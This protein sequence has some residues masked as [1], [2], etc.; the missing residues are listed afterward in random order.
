VVREKF[1]GARGIGPFWRDFPV[2]KVDAPHIPGHVPIRI[3]GPQGS[4]PKENPMKPTLTRA[5]IASSTALFALM[6]APTVAN[7]QTID[8]GCGTTIT[9]SCTS[10][11]HYT[12]ND[13]WLGGGPTSPNCPDY[14][15]NDW[16]HETGTGKGISHVN[17]NK[18]G[19]EWLTN[20]WNGDASITFYAAG[21]IDV[22][23]DSDGN[24]VSATPTRS[25]PPPTCTPVSTVADIL[26]DANPERDLGRAR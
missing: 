7:A 2:N 13:Q 14:I 9:T 20:T 11:I 15:N 12:D 24:V 5:A 25:V 10:T 23:T 8:D 1:P 6:V 22:V 17:I 4:P 21:N 19:D 18:D 26:A 16:G 3:D